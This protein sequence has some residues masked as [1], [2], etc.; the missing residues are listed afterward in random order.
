MRSKSNIGPDDGGFA[1]DLV[2]TELAC[3]PG[4]EVSVV[5][6]GERIEGTA[7]EILA[8]AEATKEREGGAVSAASTFLTALLADG[9]M[10]VKEIQANAEGAA[11][12]WASIRRAKNDLGVV[13]Q[14]SGFGGGGGGW[15]WAL[16]NHRRS[17]VL[18]DAQEKK[19]S[20]Y[21]HLCGNG[22]AEGDGEGEVEI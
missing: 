2:Q 11:I 15:E 19:L 22:S 4:I 5:R 10:A 1:Y 20:T 13:A 16:P 8:E 14:R 3:H 17:K 21:E 18:K 9:P 7:R 6:W 12:S